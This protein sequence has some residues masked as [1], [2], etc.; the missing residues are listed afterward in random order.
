[1]P[2][3]TR[4]PR[5]ERQLADARR[6]ALIEAALASLKRVAAPYSESEK[7]ALF[8]NTAMDFYRLKFG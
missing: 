1:M 2:G 3:R 7:A 8:S 6:Q 4:K 5:F